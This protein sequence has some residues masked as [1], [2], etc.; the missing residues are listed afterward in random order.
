MKKIILGLCFTVGFSAASFASVSGVSYGNDKILA[1]ESINSKIEPLVGCYY[2][3]TLV[4]VACDG[5]RRNVNVGEGIG[6]C[7]PGDGDGMNYMTFKTQNTC[8]PLEDFT[9]AL[10]TANEYMDYIPNL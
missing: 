1:A 8:G 2:S 4:L 5:S 3:Y 9:K 10:E 7:A 6:A